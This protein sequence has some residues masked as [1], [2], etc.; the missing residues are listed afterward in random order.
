MSRLRTR[1]SAALLC[2]LALGA[3]CAG[4]DP[5]PQANEPPPFPGSVGATAWRTTEDPPEQFGAA[6]DRF[7]SPHATLQALMAFGV[8]QEGGL[9]PGQRLVGDILDADADAA[10][11]WL[12]LTGTEDDSVAGQEILLYMLKDAGGWFI[13]RL[14]FRDH[15]RRAVDPGGE[16]CV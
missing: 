4:P 5:S 1:A 7:D 14:A 16:L 15:C 3:G 2:L 10:R 6:G 11:A 8:Q 12:H 13:D 9:P